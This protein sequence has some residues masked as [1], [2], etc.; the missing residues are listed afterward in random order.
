M[1][2]GLLSSWTYDDIFCAYILYYIVNL[3]YFQYDLFLNLKL[4]SFNS[5]KS[6]LIYIFVLIL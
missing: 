4:F 1:L 2:T 5:N 3:K 6:C